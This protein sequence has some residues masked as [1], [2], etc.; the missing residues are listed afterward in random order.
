MLAGDK[1][2]PAVVVKVKSEVAW[3]YLPQ[4]D[5][6]TLKKGDYH[7]Y[8]HNDGEYHQLILLEIYHAVVLSMI[9]DDQGH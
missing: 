2:R 7:L 1:L 3:K 5:L 4:F 6:L 9:H 8:S